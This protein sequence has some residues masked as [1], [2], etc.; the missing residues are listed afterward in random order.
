MPPV[1][2]GLFKTFTAA[3]A[4]CG[5]LFTQSAT[6]NDFSKED[7]KKLDQVEDYL[8]DLKSFAAR[9]EQNVAGMQPSTGVFYFKRPGRFLWQYETPDPV[10]LVSDGG[11]IY[12][13]DDSNN[14][15]NQV[16][17]EGIA[18]FLTREK[19]NLTD[20]KFKVEYI[21]NRNGLLHVAIRLKDDAAGDIGNTLSLTFLKGPLQLRQITTT[22]QFDQPVE[23]LFFNIRE[24]AD[25][26][27]QIFKFTPPQYREN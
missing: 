15:T 2:L 7:L 4:L 20:G 24:N 16:P 19:I 14:Q 9:F 18:D 8:N 25:L 21:N 26:D 10:K 3:F 1:R 12:F 27:T 22:N 11:L 23:V 5:L 13:H 6:A 17:R